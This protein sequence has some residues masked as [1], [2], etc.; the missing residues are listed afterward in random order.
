MSK[1]R[2]FLLSAVVAAAAF[3][4][5]VAITTDGR[6]DCPTEDSCVADYRDGSWTITE[7]IP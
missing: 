4:G 6:P 5:G 7:V 3:V 1:I 2:A